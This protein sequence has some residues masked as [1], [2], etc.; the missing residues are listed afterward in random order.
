MKIFAY[1]DFILKRNE[2]G[3]FADD[4]HILFIKS[5][6]ENYFDEFMLASRVSPQSGSGYYF[7]SDHENQILELPYYSSVSD[8]LK[9]PN[10][11]WKAYRLLKSLIKEFDVFWITWPHP[12]SFLIL[13]MIGKDKPVILFVR[14]NLEALIEVR[15]SGIKR[16]AGILFTRLVY[17][18]ASIFRSHAILVTV[19]EEMY[20]VLSPDF[21]ASRYISDSI[22]PKEYALPSREKRTPGVLKLLFVGR[23]E[24]EKGLPELIQAFKLIDEKL[25]SRLTIVGEGVSKNDAESLVKELGL[26]DKV[27]FKGYV[28]FG[29]ELFEAY[30]SHDLLMI[31]SYSEGL[32]KI[33]NESRAFAI[34]IVSTKVGGI[35]NELKDGQTCLFVKPRNPAQLAAAA[36]KLAEDMELYASIS[37]NLSL[38]FQKNSLEF[39]SEEFSNFVKNHIK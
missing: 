37:K 29:K 13:L 26:G 17:N 23:L 9:N 20:K 32:P 24:P 7:F 30:A 15:Y 2:E 25:E 10:I 18:F 19:G 11:F 35:A 5:T 8:F 31:S 16:W 6:C 36:L 22:V 28:P 14:Q 39:W 3:I 33:I 21:T 4:S 12:V 27:D 34:P 1:N 38:E